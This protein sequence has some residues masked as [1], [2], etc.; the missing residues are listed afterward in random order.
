MFIFS[1][2][3]APGNYF[4]WILSVAENRGGNHGEGLTPENERRE[5]VAVL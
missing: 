3:P 2:S 5:M 4:N 1:F